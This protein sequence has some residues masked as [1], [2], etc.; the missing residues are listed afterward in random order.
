MFSIK[1]AATRGADT[2]CPD[3][4]AGRGD[5]V[6]PGCRTGS[7]GCLQAATEASWTAERSE[8][9]CSGAAAFC[10]AH[11]SSETKPGK[12]HR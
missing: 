6:G 1:V 5:V 8:R 11:G 10:V 7:S 12:Y 2:H 3:I 4:R 9:N